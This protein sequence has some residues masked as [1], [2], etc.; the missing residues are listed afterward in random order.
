MPKENY[1]EIEV[2]WKEQRPWNELS[3]EVLSAQNVL[4]QIYCDS[5]IYGR[6][7]LAYIG[8]TDQN[9]ISRI[10]DHQQ[11]FFQYAQN[12]HFSI[13]TI[14]SEPLKL[15]IP[16]SILIANHKPFY[17]KE[18]IHELDPD[19]KNHKIIVINNGEHGSLKNACTNYWWV[20]KNQQN[21]ST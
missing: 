14:K 9:G 20:N 3:E 7:V 1:Q 4:Y 18:Y 8:K 2:E 19:A 5:H 17:N 21:Q 13:G 16:E 6:N 11:S 12:I 15:E 10:K